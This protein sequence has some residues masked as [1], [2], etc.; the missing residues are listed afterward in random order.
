M[1]S[2]APSTSGAVFGALGS[3]GI[4]LALTA[5]LVLGVMGKGKV[6]FQTRGATVTAF[7]AGTA[8]IA[9][10]KIW[11]NPGKVTEQGLTGLG[12]GTGNGPFGDVGIG[13]IAL[14]LLIVLIAAPLTPFGAAVTAM[15]ASFVW[16]AAGD[17]SIW[18]MPV[19]LG[20]AILMMAGG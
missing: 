7:L 6:K 12:V 14:I 16:P 2:A 1:Y 17:G 3:G 15:I 20:A 13:A 11:A 19:Q 8:Y 9:A 18:A 10:G 4:A 5:L